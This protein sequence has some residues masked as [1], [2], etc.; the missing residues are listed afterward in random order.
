MFRAVHMR[1]RRMLDFPAVALS[2]SGAMMRHPLGAL[3]GHDGGF[4]CCRG[5]LLGVRVGMPGAF[6]ALEGGPGTVF[7]AAAVVVFGAVCCT[8]GGVFAFA[9]ICSLTFVAVVCC[10]LGEESGHD[11]GLLGGWFWFG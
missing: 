7:G 11:R 8:R 9:A 3:V 2:E 10:F 5:G 4:T 1:H 6:F